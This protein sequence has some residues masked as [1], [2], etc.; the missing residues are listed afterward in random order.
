MWSSDGQRKKFG[1][2]TIA[3]FSIPILVTL[4][5]VSTVNF[6]NRYN[7]VVYTN[8]IDNTVICNSIM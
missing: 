3:K 5:L 4:E 8:N 1:A 6:Y 7:T 2:Q